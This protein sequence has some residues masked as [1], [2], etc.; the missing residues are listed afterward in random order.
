LAIRVLCVGK[1][2]ALLERTRQA[3]QTIDCEIIKSTS[4]A[5][6]LFLAQKNFPCLVLC[7]PSL[8]EGT[9]KELFFALSQ[10]QDLSKIPFFVVVNSTDRESEADLRNSGIDCM[11]CTPDD[12]VK[13]GSLLRPF[14]H[15]IP[16]HRPEETSE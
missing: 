13:F 11:R 12:V 15:E 16:D 10:E 2:D 14:L 3:L 5:L 7:E 9:P 6:A 1:T 4:V 8:V